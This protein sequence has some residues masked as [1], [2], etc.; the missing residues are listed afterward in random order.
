MPL[1]SIGDSVR[2]GSQIVINSSSV[3]VICLLLFLLLLLL[4]NIASC[5]SSRLGLLPLR[6]IPGPGLLLLCCCLVSSI[7]LLLLLL[8]LRCRP[9]Q[10]WA[11][12]LRWTLLLRRCWRSLLPPALAACCLRCLL[13]CSAAAG[14]HRRAV[15]L[16]THKSR[17]QRAGG[18]Q[19]LVAAWETRL[20]VLERLGCVG[21]QQ[22]EGVEDQG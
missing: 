17:K 6:F 19:A 4:L 14:R 9:Q 21:L 20:E 10:A 1:H 5:S 7:L 15:C 12:P 2:N 22:A 11:P 3:V 8:L 18:L 16:L 13:R